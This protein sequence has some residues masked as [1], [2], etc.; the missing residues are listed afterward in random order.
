MRKVKY[1]LVVFFILFSFSRCLKQQFCETGYG[2]IETEERF[3]NDFSKINIKISA[4]VYISQGEH[5]SVI[6]EAQRNIINVIE[7]NLLNEEL[8]IEFD[9]CVSFNDG[10]NIYITV[11]DIESI[12]FSGSGAVYTEGEINTNY[13]ELVINGSGNIECKDLNVKNSISSIINGSGNITIESEQTTTNHNIE[14]NASGNLYAYGFPTENVDIEIIASGN[15]YV[16]A[17]LMLNINIIGSGSVYY[18]GNPDINID[19]IGTGSVH[20]SN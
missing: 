2:E 1:L 7:T 10:I 19:I 18:I 5:Q 8:E 6:I 3:I 12:K 20:N 13:L 17:I 11:K 4:N 14:I 15:V 16:Y 9:E